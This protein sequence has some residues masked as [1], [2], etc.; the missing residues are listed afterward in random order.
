M[1]F[2]SFTGLVAGR[3]LGIFLVSVKKFMMQNAQ[4]LFIE[5]IIIKLKKPEH[6]TCP[7]FS[8]IL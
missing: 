4:D 3:I 5:T 8:T 6:F 1:N 7:V 2:N